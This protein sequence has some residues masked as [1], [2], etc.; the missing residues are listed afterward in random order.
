MSGGWSQRADRPAALACRLATCGIVLAGIVLMLV[1]APRVPY[2]DA[3][4][5][6]A[7]LLDQPFLAG[8]ISADNGHREILP[9]TLRW[10]ELHAFGGDQTL[11]IVLGAVLALA[12]TVA[13]LRTIAHAQ[14]DPASRAAAALI[15]ALGVL[16][17]GNERALAHAHE[18]VRV[19]LI[20]LCL[21]LALTRV[22]VDRADLRATAGAAALA[23]LATLTFG[24]GIASF[25]AV[26]VAMLLG[27]AT[28]AAWC[29]WAIGLAVACALYLGGASSSVTGTLA[30]DP[31]GQFALLLRWLASP[32]VYVF[33]PLLD[34]AIA[35]QL[36]GDTLR[37][38]AT[39]IADGFVAHFGSVQTSTW[40]QTLIG[41]AGL[42]ALSAA[43]RRAWRAP[44]A[45]VPARRVALGVAWFGLAVGGLIAL[46]RSAYFVEFPDQLHAP[47][48]LPWSSLFWSGLFSTALL[49][50]GRWPRPIL[51]LLV[52]SVI[53]PS[54]LW[55]AGLARSMQAHAD[56]TATAAIV[57]LLPVSQGL[58]ETV[59]GELTTALPRLRRAG[60]GP[61]AWPEAR[62]LGWTVR[63]E[64]VRRV[65][66]RNLAAIPAGNRIGAPGWLIRFESVTPADGRRLILDANGVL[67][68]LAMPDAARGFDS[69]EGWLGPG[70]EPEQTLTI[71]E[72]IGTPLCHVE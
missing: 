4:R 7:K 23:L 10:I 59:V 57:G 41:I 33:W 46:S 44:T 16:W 63:D 30:L 69:W 58:G 14:L 43:S 28:P 31:V 72:R 50:P 9:N 37:A 53:V 48:Y 24:S 21:I 27:R 29:V 60:V 25:G 47:R 61:Y 11:G 5:L 17:L 22:A 56:R 3:W 32:F 19:Y 36:P 20:V 62:C 45:T 70:H 34:P 8:V 39:A 26:A 51:A 1:A 15:A 71:A 54:S 40:P 35:A 38:A 13:W 49:T 68:G 2:A 42:A 18:S 55:M 64:S 52:A 66:A 67:R 6:Y 65:D 12:A